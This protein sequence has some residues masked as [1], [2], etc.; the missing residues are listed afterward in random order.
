MKK[1][2]ITQLLKPFIKG[3]FSIDDSVKAMGTY[4]LKLED[5]DDS[6]IELHKHS[7]DFRDKKEHEQS[8]TLLNVKD[9]N[10]HLFFDKIKSVHLLTEYDVSFY[11]EYIKYIISF[12]NIHREYFDH[13]D[14]KVN[15]PMKDLDKFVIPFT[16]NIAA[17]SNFFYSSV[18]FDKQYGPIQMITNSL[19][20]VELSKIPKM[21][22]YLFTMCFRINE[23]LYIYIDGKYQVIDNYSITPKKLAAIFMDD[24]FKY[25][26]SVLNIDFNEFDCDYAEDYI[27]GY[28]MATI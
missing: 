22:R 7:F 13:F 25:I 12:S 19:S 17:T 10:S 18:F 8:I 27:N 20:N 3:D 16:E 9:T 5:N 6:F 15:Y 21:S 23:K 26:L 11:K 4:T 28:N 1:K 14:S 24:Y 2:E